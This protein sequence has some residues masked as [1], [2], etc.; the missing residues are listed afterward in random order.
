MALKRNVLV[1]H[2][3]ALGDFV[4][5]WP[6]VLA[7][8]RLYP[9]SRV[10]CVTHAQKGMLAE[11]VLRVDWADADTGGWHA[12]HDNAAAL[13]DRSR[14]LLVEAHSIFSFAASEDET[15][16]ANVR[17]LNAQATAVQLRARPPEDFAGHVVAHL[18][19]QLRPHH[20]VAA[21]VEQIVRSISQRGLLPHRQAGDDVVIHPGSG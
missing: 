11:K 18:L 12:L 7:L 16:S 8:A 4:L 19:D 6:L 17:R 21:A 10:V 9:Q 14:N 3:G 1:F 5:T 13:P 20:A 15:W 2:S